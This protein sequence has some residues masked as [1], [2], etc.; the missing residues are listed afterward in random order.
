[1]KK[2]ILF[3]ALVLTIKSYSQ[4][5]DIAVVGESYGRNE[6]ALFLSDL[7]NVKSELFIRI[8]QRQQQFNF[9]PLSWQNKFQCKESGFFDGGTCTDSKVAAEVNSFHLPHVNF[10]LVLS[11]NICG[12]GGGTVCLCGACYHN[13]INSGEGAVHEISHT[14]WYFQHTGS[15]FMQSSCNHGACM[16]NV[17][18]SLSEYISINQTMNTL[19]GTMNANLPTVTIT[20]PY[21]GYSTDAMGSLMVTA[22]VSAEAQVVRIL[23]DGQEK[24]TNGYWANHDRSPYFNPV[25]GVQFWITNLSPGQHIITVTGINF[26]NQE[27][28]QSINITIN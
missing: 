14:L 10:I 15:Y 20:S 7:Q 13:A 25:T 1:M 3:I 9:I 2:I 6:Q 26:N 21:N 27:S 24:I 8:S 16:W 28:S 4:T 11:K 12:G 5:I 18:Y 19:A 23:W 22:N 17:T